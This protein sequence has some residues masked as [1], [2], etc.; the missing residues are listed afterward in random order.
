MSLIKGVTLGQY[1]PAD[2]FIHKLDPRCKL[3]I[4]VLSMILIFMSGNFPAMAMWASLIIFIAKR[5][6][7][8]AITLIRSAKPILVLIIFTSLLHIFFTGGSTVIFTIGPLKATA[9]GTITAFRMGLRL[10]LLVLFTA[11]LTFT[12]SPSELSDGLEAAFGPF[13]RFGFP[14]HEVAMMMTI[15]LRFIPTLFEETERIINAQ[16]SRG[17]DFVSGGLIKRAKA[18]IPV[19]IPLFVLVFKRADTLASAMEARCYRGGK[20]RVRMYPLK[21]GSPENKALTVF[22]VFSVAVICMNRWI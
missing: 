20:G 1:I 9:E 11:L 3:L 18:Y 2:S 4:T 16:V 12:T 5:S 15:A 19:L 17:A 14:A 8:P 13:T 22:V 21:W 6:Q 10:Y 7:I